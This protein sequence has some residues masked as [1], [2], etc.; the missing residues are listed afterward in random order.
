MQRPDPDL[1][2]AGQA[3]QAFPVRWPS[4]HGPD[5]G[6]HPRAGA[7]P[8]AERGGQT[9]DDHPRW[10]QA[11]L[12]DRPGAARGAGPAWGPGAAAAVGQGSAPRREGVPAGVPGD[13]PPRLV[14]A[15]ARGHAQ[16]R[17]DLTIQLGLKFLAVST[18]LAALARARA[19]LELQ[20][21]DTEERAAQR[22]RHAVGLCRNGMMAVQAAHLSRWWLTGDSVC[23]LL[24]VTTSA[25]GLARVRRARGA[26]AAPALPAELPAELPTPEGRADVAA[27]PAGAV[28]KKVSRARRRSP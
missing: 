5:L 26:R 8:M 28:P 19:L 15:G 11:L 13:R 4:R 2:G 12:P 6:G 10:L 16:R 1:R 3:S 25:I 27:V 9:A 18:A 23:G 24:G 20:R 17:E 22:R 21:E 14:E 7:D